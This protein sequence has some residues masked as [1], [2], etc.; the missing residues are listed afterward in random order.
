MIKHEYVFELI[1]KSS[2]KLGSTQWQ[3]ESEEERYIRFGDFTR[4]DSTKDSPAYLVSK[5][6]IIFEVFIYFKKLINYQDLNTIEGT[7]A[8]TKD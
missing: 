5:R 8:M 4:E 3:K 2:K 7:P 1:S 6:Y